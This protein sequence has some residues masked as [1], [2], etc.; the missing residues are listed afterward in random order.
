MHSPIY[1]LCVLQAVLSCRFRAALRVLQALGAWEGLLSRGLLLGL[2]LG[3]QGL[4]GGQLVQYVR[5]ATIHAVAQPH[6]AVGRMEAVA[7]ALPQEWFA[8]G[9]CSG[10]R[11]MLD[12]WACSLKLAQ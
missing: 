12:R 2:A 4:V 5:A 11:Q 9:W 6:T 10:R 8:G 1:G 7:E 3:Q